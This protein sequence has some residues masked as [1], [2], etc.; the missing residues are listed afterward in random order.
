MLLVDCNAHALTHYAATHCVQDGI[1]SGWLCT[2]PNAPALQQLLDDC[3]HR[4]LLWASSNLDAGDVVVLH[5]RLLHMS[6]TNITDRIRI[7]CD[8]RWQPVDEPIDQ[9]C[10]ATKIMHCTARHAPDT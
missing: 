5:L 6:T 9:R 3:T 2:E 8:T 10:A 7:S 1:A 4:K